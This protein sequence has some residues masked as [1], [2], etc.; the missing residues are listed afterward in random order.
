[1]RVWR[2]FGGKPSE[3]MAARRGSVGVEFAMIGSMLITLTLAVFGAGMTLW[4]FVGLES[5]AGSAARCGAIGTDCAT[6][7]QATAFARTLADKRAG[8]GTV[9]PTDTV[10]SVSGATACNGIA[11]KFFIVTITSSWFASGAL[12]IVA[13][14]FNLTNITVSS[15]FPMA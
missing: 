15:C 9:A 10:T 11:G 7:A 13:Q 3:C 2:L 12:S 8:T 14:P 1:M 4:V 6:T 5:A